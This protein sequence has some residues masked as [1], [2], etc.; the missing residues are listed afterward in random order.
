MVAT[1]VCSMQDNT[2]YD[3]LSKGDDDLARAACRAATA[4]ERGNS[5]GED[6][7]RKLFGKT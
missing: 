3:G 4:A 2:A 7:R 5:L 6:H 1:A